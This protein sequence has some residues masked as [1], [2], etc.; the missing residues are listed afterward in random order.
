MR[1][2]RTCSVGGAPAATDGVMRKAE[3]RGIFLRIARKAVLRRP[4][5]P[6][7]GVA[8][9]HGRDTRR[10]CSS[11]GR[12]LQSHCRGQGFDSP[13]LHQPPMKRDGSFRDRLLYNPHHIVGAA[14]FRSVISLDRGYTRSER[15]PPAHGRRPLDRP[16]I[17]CRMR[18][19][20]RVATSIGA[21]DRPSH[22]P[23]PIGRH[24]ARP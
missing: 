2:E 7:N 4:R 19:S 13:Q 3:S 23:I 9:D 15:P 24:P 20:P 21:G 8:P 22:L 18:V 12:A 1:H 11:D 10:G 16:A 14:G 6:A 17:A 5:S